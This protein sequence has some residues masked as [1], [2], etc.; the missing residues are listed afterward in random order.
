[1]RPP[2]QRLLAK[3]L[4]SEVSLLKSQ[5]Q[6]IP[7]LLLLEGVRVIVRD[8]LIIIPGNPFHRSLMIPSRCE[9]IIHN[10]ILDFLVVKDTGGAGAWAGICAAGEFADAIWF[11][12][13]RVRQGKRS[14]IL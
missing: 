9:T 8:P 1:M 13:R 10:Y 6:A 14:T 5:E 2:R 4:V 7:N 11:I 3:S 12:A